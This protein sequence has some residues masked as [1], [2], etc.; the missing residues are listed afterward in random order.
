MPRVPVVIQL[1]WSP[2]VSL[3][4][5]GGSFPDVEGHKKQQCPVGR[6]VLPGAATGAAAGKAEPGQLGIEE[7]TKLEPGTISIF[8]VAKSF[9]PGCRF[10]CYFPF[11][12]LY[13]VHQHC[14][15]A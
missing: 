5:T 13:A 9:G 12:L 2:G 6:E 10:R 15:T 4:T 8:L 3:V 1:P 14:L 11:S 7:G